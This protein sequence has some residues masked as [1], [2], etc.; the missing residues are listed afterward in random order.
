MHDSVQM[1][2]LS[3]RIF[4]AYNIR[5]EFQALLDG[6]TAADLLNI[7]ISAPASPDTSPVGHD[8]LAASAPVSRR[9]SPPPAQPARGALSPQLK[10]RMSLPSTVLGQFSTPLNGQGLGFDEKLQKSETAKQRLEMNSPMSSTTAKHDSKSPNLGSLKLAGLESPTITDVKS[11]HCEWRRAP[12]DVVGTPREMNASPHG[13]I[14]D[15]QKR[16]TSDNFSNGMPMPPWLLAVAQGLFSLGI[17]FLTCV[18]ALPSWEWYVWV[19]K[20]PQPWGH[21]P[22]GVYKG[23]SISGLLVIPVVISFKLFVIS[24]HCFCFLI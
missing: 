20:M 24:L 16:K 22:L 11:P 17:V 13:I 1:A 5:V 6:L 12:T 18:C 4:A 2:E 21:I 8:R 9:G 10:Q 14:I 3:A 7:I 19:S 15:F 23:A